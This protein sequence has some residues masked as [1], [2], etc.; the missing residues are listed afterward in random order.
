M[1]L[2]GKR[3]AAAPCCPT[4]RRVTSCHHP[5]WAWDGRGQ[6]H[7]DSSALSPRPGW[8]CNCLA[9]QGTGTAVA[10][11]H[12]PIGSEPRAPVLRLE[13]GSPPGPS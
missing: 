4:L 11:L 13:D 9:P 8:D 6:A 12:V 3:S 2:P 5:L 1:G 10:L 7:P